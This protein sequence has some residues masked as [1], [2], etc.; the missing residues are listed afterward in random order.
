MKKFLLL[1]LLLFAVP[2]HAYNIWLGTPFTHNGQTVVPIMGSNIPADLW[3]FGNVNIVTTGTVA[4]V[5]GPLY[6]V[7][8]VW[9][10]DYPNIPTGVCVAYYDD[11]GLGYPEWY[12]SAYYDYYTCGSAASSGMF[13]AFAVTG[14]GTVKLVNAV[15]N[16]HMCFDG[17]ASMTVS[18]NEVAVGSGGGGGGGGGAGH[19][20]GVM[21]G[22]APAKPTPKGKPRTTWATIKALYR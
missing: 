18:S 22:E 10:D 12:V 21:V 4:P 13:G 8:N 17:A 2:A 16:T 1:A 5:G 7:G 6:Q 15:G 3:E 11:I 19:E 20:E 14:S 9:P